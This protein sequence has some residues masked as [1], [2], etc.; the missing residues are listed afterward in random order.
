MNISFTKIKMRHS[1]GLHFFLPDKFRK[2]FG[3]HKKTSLLECK[4]NI[5]TIIIMYEQMMITSNRSV[6]VV[7]VRTAFVL[8]KIIQ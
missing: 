6:V 8:K 3:D 2:L 4:I 5:L 1:K 7:P